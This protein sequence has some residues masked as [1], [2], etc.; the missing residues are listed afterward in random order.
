MIDPF[1]AANNA[2]AQLQ[3]QGTE[4]KPYSAITFAVVNKD[5]GV[6]GL[7]I[8]PTGRLIR[9]NT[10]AGIETVTAATRTL[11]PSEAGLVLYCARAA[12]I[13]FTLPP[14][15]SVWDFEFQ[16]A[17]APTTDITITSA[18]ADT[19]C[20]Y[21][22]A[23]TGGDESLNGNAAGDVINFKAN[24]ALPGDSIKV[25]CDGTTVYATCICKA[26]GAIT[27]TG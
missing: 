14:N 7:S 8:G 27:I 15:A 1:L 2:I 18:T 17:T 11:L 25:R 21:P 9:T 22:V 24:T 10:A 3:L 23:S 19:I 13:A 20:G 4:A 5:S 16:I 26:T 6:V 12:G